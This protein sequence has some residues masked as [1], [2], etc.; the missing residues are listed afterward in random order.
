MKVLRFLNFF[1]FV[2]YLYY[3]EINFTIHSILYNLDGQCSLTINREISDTQLIGHILT[4][5]TLNI[6]TR[7][8]EPRLPP[9][10]YISNLIWFLGLPPKLELGFTVLIQWHC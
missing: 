4:G 9:T 7:K 3:N 10:E 6:P 8:Y 2:F 1:I 5:T